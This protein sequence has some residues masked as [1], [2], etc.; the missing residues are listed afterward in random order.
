MYELSEPKFQLIKLYCR[1]TNSIEDELIKHFID[2]SAKI[3][4]SAISDK[5]TPKDLEE[6]PRFF[7]ALQ[8][9]VR[10]AYANRGEST[11]VNI[12][13]FDNQTYNLI[14]QLRAEFYENK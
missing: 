13:Y 11:E 7:F 9:K 3:I 2:S 12:N 8:R 4:A 10:E 5:L 6:D 14:N 1:V